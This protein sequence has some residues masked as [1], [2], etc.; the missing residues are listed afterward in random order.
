MPKPRD[1]LR[2]DVKAHIDFGHLKTR[3]ISPT[4]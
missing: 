1:E 2:A 4:P 3:T